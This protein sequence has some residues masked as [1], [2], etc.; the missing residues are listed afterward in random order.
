MGNVS[1][2][3]REDRGLPIAGQSTERADAAR[4]R[5]RVR[6]A[7]ARILAAG[8]VDGLSVDAV[9]REAGVGVGTVYRRFGDRTGL[10][11]ALLSDR[12]QEFQAA[13]M[14]GP[15]PLGPGAAP[16]DRLRAF[17]HALVDR[18]IGQHDLTMLAETSKPG[19]RYRSGPYSV[20]HTH[21]AALLSETR[22]HTDV[23]YLADALLAP[24]SATLIDYQ[25][26]ERGMSADAIKSGLDD[27]LDGR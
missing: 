14:S 21:V 20:Y 6:A 2:R 16:E 15:P 24:L 12:E 27:L 9:A 18:V 8:G 10:M 1:E 22:P 26:S 11:F 5:R 3:R 4:N 19:S 23:R 13:F 7:A 25:H 17:L